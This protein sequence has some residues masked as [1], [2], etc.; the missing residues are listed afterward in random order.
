[1]LAKFEMKSLKEKDNSEDLGI[2][3]MIV[4]TLRECSCEQCDEPFVS[5]KRMELFDY[6]SDYWLLKASSTSR[7]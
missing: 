6:L 5:I 3:G 2:D 7:H 1:M 4:L